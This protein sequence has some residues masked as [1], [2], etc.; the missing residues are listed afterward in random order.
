MK[1]C[2]AAKDISEKEREREIPIL[3]G[4]PFQTKFAEAS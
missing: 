1:K 3:L 4:F 2:S